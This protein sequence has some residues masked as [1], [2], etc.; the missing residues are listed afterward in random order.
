METIHSIKP[1]IAVLVSIC[2]VPFLVLSKRPNMRETWTFAAA[3]IK[4]LLVLSMLPVI[5]AGNQIVYTLGRGGAG[6]GHPV[7]GGCTGDVV[8][9]CGRIPLDC[10]QRLFHRVYAGA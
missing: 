3:I 2:V 9:L 8:R 4:L 10:D 7:P 5:L 1:L 6:G